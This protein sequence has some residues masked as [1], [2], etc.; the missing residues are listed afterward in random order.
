MKDKG[1]KTSLKVQDH[2]E[3]PNLSKDTPLPSQQSLE[4]LLKTP[5]PA[6]FSREGSEGVHLVKDE[7]IVSYAEKSKHDWGSSA[8]VTMMLLI[9]VVTHV[10]QLQAQCGISHNHYY[11]ENAVSVHCIPA[12]SF[13]KSSA[14][15]PL[16]PLP[17]F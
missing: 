12:S 4:E 5:E 13:D 17:S 7:F 6:V 8:N 9:S 3:T 16:N 14:P 10:Q 11:S 15:V 1:K 2:S